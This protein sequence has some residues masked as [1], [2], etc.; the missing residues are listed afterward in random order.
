MTDEPAHA[1]ENGGTVSTAYVCSLFDY[2]ADRGL[3]PS[4]LF[5]REAAAAVERQDA[6]GSIPVLEWVRLFRIAEQATGDARIAL[7]VGEAIKPRHFGILGYITMSCSDLRE[8]IDRMLRYE[9]LVGELSQSSLTVAG[10]DACLCWH[11]PLKPTPPR[12][13]AETSMAGWVTYGRWLLGD[14]YA[15]TRVCFQHPPPPDTTEH[16]RIFGCPVRFGAEHTALVFPRAY[17]DW[18][19]T[20]RDP[21][22]RA[23]LDAQAE[24]RL[25]ELRRLSPLHRRTREQVRQ[26]LMQGPPELDAVARG[27]GLSP[28]TLERRLQREGLSFRGVVDET[29][30]SYARELLANPRARLS[31]IALLLGYSEQSAFSRAFRRWAGVSPARYRASIGT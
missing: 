31:E 3:S 8:A 21:A 26:A 30:F 25:A 23:L 29:R 12:V 9:A 28:R 16:R 22:M 5:G 10:E 2:L 1:L 14:D 17:L 11:S 27:L 6:F 13:L 7:H 15:I 18:P 20:Q 4:A 24:A 19:L